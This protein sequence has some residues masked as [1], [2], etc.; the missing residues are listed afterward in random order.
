MGRYVTTDKLSISINFIT[1]DEQ[2]YAVSYD[3]G[4]PGTYW[5]PP[6]PAGIDTLYIREGEFWRELDYGEISDSLNER[7]E[8][9]LLS[10][11]EEQYEREYSC[12]Y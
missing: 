3:F 8:K 12:P 9:V 11:L 7:I 6:E 10:Q 5:D 2:E 1:L 4:C